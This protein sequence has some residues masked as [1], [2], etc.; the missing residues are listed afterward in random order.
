MFEKARLNVLK[1]MYLSCRIISRSG[2][3]RSDS[4]T[5]ILHARGKFTNITLTG[6]C[7][8][9]AAPAVPYTV[10]GNHLRF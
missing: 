1:S 4:E 3:F 10:A 8:S 6:W 9:I 2:A 7:F 5:L